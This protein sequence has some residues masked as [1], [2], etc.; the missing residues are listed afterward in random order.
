LIVGTVLIDI[1][2]PGTQSLKDKRRRIKSLTSRVRNKFNVSIAEVA[3]NDNRRR[4]QIGA[5]VV[6]NDRALVDH[7]LSK[8]A[9][10]VDNEPEINMTDY[11]VE[12]F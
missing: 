7:V 6:S 4:G 5:A 11:Q 10:L 12:I 9:A 2:L 8:V 1:H 3:Y